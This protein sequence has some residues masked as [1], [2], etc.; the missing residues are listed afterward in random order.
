M[1]RNRPFIYVL[2][3][4]YIFSAGCAALVVGAGAGAAGVIWYKGK[5]Q[6]TVSYSVPRVHEAAKA[7]LGDLNINITEDRSDDLTSEVRGVLADGK[8]VWIDAESTGSSTTKLT[9]RVGMLG[10]KAF[11]L[12]IRDAIKSHL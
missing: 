1:R 12:R 4:F 9:I 10:D 7:G 3:V 2:L 11:S 5:L 6:E 8:K